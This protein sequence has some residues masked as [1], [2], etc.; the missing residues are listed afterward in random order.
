MK[1]SFGSTNCKE[2]ENGSLGLIETVH[3]Q[4]WNVQH[5]KR[6]LAPALAEFH[7]QINYNKLQLMIPKD[8]KISITVPRTK[9][10]DT[11]KSASSS[12]QH[13]ILDRHR[14][15]MICRFRCQSD[16]HFATHRSNIGYRLSTNILPACNRHDINW[17]FAHYFQYFSKLQHMLLLHNT[18][19]HKNK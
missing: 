9:Y 12:Q 10:G 13:F 19:K 4:Y 8:Q 7:F 2:S 15:D 18:F 6:P 16:A 3:W 5:G 14:T 17:S 1:W 11:F